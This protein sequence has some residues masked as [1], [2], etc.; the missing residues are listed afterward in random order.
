VEKYVAAT[1]TR[2]NVDKKPDNFLR[3]YGT[4]V[5]ATRIF[6]NFV[7]VNIEAAQFGIHMLMKWNALHLKTNS[8]EVSFF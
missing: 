8:A 6:L 5:T 7:V 2:Q 3:E 1:L 4:T